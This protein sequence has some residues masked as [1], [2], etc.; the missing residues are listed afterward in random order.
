MRVVGID[1]FG[2]NLRYA[3]GEYVMSGGRA[4]TSEIGTLVR[5]RTDEGL[6]GWGEITPLGNRYLPT[7]WAEVRAALH[8]LAPA[9]LGKDPTNVS[10]VRRTLDGVLLGGTYAKAAIDVACWDLLGKACGQPI[11]TLLGGVLQEDFPL[12]EAVPLTSPEA[13]ADF[14][15]RREEAGI[16][17]FQ[18]KVGNDPLE[19][20]ARTRAV[21]DAAASDTL[22]VAD[23][24]GGWNLRAAQI[25]VA[26]M[27]GLPVFV[28]QPCRK[29]EDC[30]FAMRHSSLPL[31]LDETVL[32]TTDVFRAK[33]DAGAVSVNIKISRVGGLT[34]AARMRDLTQDLDMMVSIEDTWGG[35]IVSAAV[36]HLAASTEAENFQNASFMND[37][38]D[39]HVAGHQPRSRNGRGAAPTGP[40]LGITVQTD[41]LESVFH[42]A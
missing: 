18:L 30:V 39:G 25:A 15:V 7:H 2:Y 28:E 26:S 27:A 24:N 31:V 17:R 14:V 34:G 37:W 4:A 20:A 16:A 11:A 33:Y 40:G 13:M 19:D 22:V 35:D 9:L 29:T 12:Y 6:E 3:H 32:T 8:T 1:C 36:S 23:A 21:V 41:G 10:A 5:L 42:I 38:T